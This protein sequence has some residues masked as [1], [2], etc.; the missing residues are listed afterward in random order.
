MSRRIRSRRLFA[1]AALAPLA[2]LPVACGGGGDD[3]G[4]AV[5]GTNHTHALA[6]SAEGHI[7]VGTHHGLLRV[8][9]E[10]DSSPELVSE[11]QHD[12][13]GLAADGSGRLLAS[14]HPDL[15]SGLPTQIGLM[16]STDGGQDWEQV[17]LEG[18][19]DFHALAASGER[20]YGWDSLGGRFLTSS[21]GGETWEDQAAPEALHWLAVSPD[22]PA[23][24]LGA[25]DAMLYRSVDGGQSFEALGRGGGLLAWD[26]G[27]EAFLLEYGSGRLLRSPNGEVWSEVGAAPFTDAVAFTALSDGTLAAVRE[28][29]TLA[30]S[31]DGGTSWSERASLEEIPS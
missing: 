5:G 6:P 31:G 16:D 24:V 1:V 26:P 25:S 13:M 8:S 11:Y 21:D 2:L 3:G 7:L 10:D 17:A 4:S 23:V 30:V 20:V 29:G 12:F 22:D 9:P 28:E 14:G 18:E 27:G 15:D 19:V